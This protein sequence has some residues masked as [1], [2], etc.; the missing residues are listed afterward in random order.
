MKKQ[1]FNVPANSRVTTNG[2]MVS[3]GLETTNLST[4]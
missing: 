4:E 3:C 1:E 2:G